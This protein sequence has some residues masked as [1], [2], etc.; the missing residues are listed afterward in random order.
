[1]LDNHDNADALEDSCATRA[2]DTYTN[3]EL[4]T[5]RHEQQGSHESAVLHADLLLP[6]HVP[7]TRNSL[8]GTVMHVY[9]APVPL[10]PPA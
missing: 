2:V 9:A 8:S 10:P 6:H 3:V 7:E 4:K 5:S 1:M